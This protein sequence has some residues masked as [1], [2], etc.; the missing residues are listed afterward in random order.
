MSVLPLFIIA[1]TLIFVAGLIVQGS[2]RLKF[3]A[4]CV[5][6]SSTWLGLLGLRLAGFNINPML[7]G[8][9]MGESVVGIYYLL[10]KKVPPAWQLFRWPYIVTMTVGV[11][12][13][14]G[15]R[16]GAMLAVALL[17]IMWLISVGI[18]VFRR[19]PSFKRIAERLIA[20]CRDW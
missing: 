10:E 14:V 6:I 12:F 11:Y 1:T 13:V 19:Y 5:A 7:I 18:Y 3:C 9:L 16:E 4:V 2:T 8:V 20:C 15:I 17:I